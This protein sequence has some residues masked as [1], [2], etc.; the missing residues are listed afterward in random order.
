MNRPAVNRFEWGVV[1]GV[2]LIAAGPSFGNGGP[3]LIKYP[4]GD[5]AAKGILA[6]LDPS[7]TPARETRLRVLKEELDVTFVAAPHRGSNPKVPSPPLALVSARYTIENP[8]DQA[9]EIDFGFPILRG[10]YTSPSGMTPMS[11]PDVRIRLN[12][13]RDVHANIISNSAIYGL[14]RQR[15]R[16]VIEKVVA[17][18]ETLRRLVSEVRASGMLRQRARKAIERAVGQ[19]QALGAAVAQDRLLADL[20]EKPADPREADHEQA[21]AALARYLTKDMKWKA[22]DVALMVEF[23]G[24]DF[25]DL[26]MFPP[27]RTHMMATV[28]H[29]SINA[30]LGPL[31]AIGEQKATQFFGQLASCFDPS[32]TAG[33]E[34]IFTAWGGDVRE[35]S[36]DLETG[37]V[38]PREITVDREALRP[39]HPLLRG[40]VSD[41]TLY[42]RVN[43][44]DPKAPITEAERASCKTVLK[45]L[46]VIFTFA[47]MNLLHYRVKFPAR[48]TQTVDVS[49]KQYA[50][51]D[52]GGPAS[53][54]LAYVVHPASLWEEFGPIHLEVFTPEGIPFRASVPC[55]E[56]G[57]Q[58]RELDPRLSPLSRKQTARFAVHRGT[59]TEKTG[60]VFLAVS[61]GAWDQRLVQPG[62]NSQIQQAARR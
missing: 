46:P 3:F 24:L 15:A 54:Q 2:V 59:L 53:Y 43:Y 37:R 26:R 23:A 25:G 30:N 51:K 47:P 13:K 28:G 11:R 50:Y 10:I 31:A 60:E 35:R 9:I 39:A 27:D 32:V 44:L 58:D 19:D 5:P 6:R 34:S 4:N 42:A 7:L 17:K 22:R 52:T 33:Y 1:L 18:D 56:A 20:M 57:T 29:H 41:P 21:R 62:K 55:R 40:G 45:N 49:Y 61:A 38:R 8:T 14:L 36:V 48:G 12:D 16:E